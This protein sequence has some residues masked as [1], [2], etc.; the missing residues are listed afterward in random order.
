MINKSISSD[1]EKK[2]KEIQRLNNLTLSLPKRKKFLKLYKQVRNIS[3]TAKML[4]IT[5]LAVHK[6]KNIDEQFK[7]EIDNVYEEICDELEEAMVSYGKSD[8]RASSDRKNYLAAYRE[9]FKNKPAEIQVN[10][11][12]NV[13]N[14][15]Q[16]DNILKKILPDNT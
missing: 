4:N 7:H 9:E 10:T 6:T 14:R 8:A 13:D 3:K 16:L 11:Q 5:P 15:G 1:P 2:K 12:I